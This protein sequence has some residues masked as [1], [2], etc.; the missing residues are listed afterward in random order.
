MF[1]LIQELV[2][3]LLKSASHPCFKKR[4]PFL[5]MKLLSNLDIT[6]LQ[7]NLEKLYLTRAMNKKNTIIYFKCFS[8]ILKWRFDRRVEGI[9]SGR[10]TQRVFVYLSKAFKCVTHN[11]R[12]NKMEHCGIRT[13]NT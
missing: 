13:N 3:L 6:G 10:N 12:I 1:L 11:T 4:G 7:Q 9:K 5:H 2:L 8:Q